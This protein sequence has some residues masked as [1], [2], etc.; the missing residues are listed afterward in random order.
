MRETSLRRTFDDFDE[1]LSTYV[2]LNSK[3]PS[4]QRVI[5]HPW[6]KRE[7]LEA[8]V[9]RLVTLWEVFVEDVL[10]GCLS[11]DSSR[12]AQFHGVVLRE[13][14]SADECRTMLTGGGYLDFQ[15]VGHVQRVAQQ[16]L[17]VNPFAAIPEASSRK[18]DE[19]IIMRNYI[20]RYS[21][22]AERALAEVYRNTYH[23]QRFR[24]PGNFLWGDIRR[25]G[26][27]R[28]GAY[29][30]A[31]RDAASAMRAPLGGLAQ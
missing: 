29:L 23:M 28:I 4:G 6:Q 22:R 12:Y 7:L 17:F 15:D 9:L 25:G 2:Y 31:L 30:D 10:V 20:C 26:P 1:S 14:L 19:L 13:D 16:I 8:L 21:G 3:I 18:I 11:S 5:Q 24:E 27:M